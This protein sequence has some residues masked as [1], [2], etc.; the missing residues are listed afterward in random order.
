MSRM[1]N[2]MNRAAM[3]KYSTSGL[4]HGG[5]ASGHSD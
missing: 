3:V 2:N 5:G 1:A 4:E